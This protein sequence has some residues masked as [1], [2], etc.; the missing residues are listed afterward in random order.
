MEFEWDERKAEGN[1]KK[2]GVS[3]HEAGT[4]FGD[5]MAITFHDSEHSEDEPRFLT[6]GLS[7]ANRLLVVAHTDRGHRVRILSARSMTRHER[8]IYEEG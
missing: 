4:V 8:R 5:P 1:L 2:H 7:R 3:F 6:F